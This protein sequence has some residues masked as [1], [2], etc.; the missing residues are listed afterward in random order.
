MGGLRRISILYNG[1]SVS[2]L[3]T[4][5]YANLELLL[6]FP[7]VITMYPLHIFPHSFSIL[8]IYSRVTFF[9]MGVIHPSWMLYFLRVM[10]SILRM[11]GAVEFTTRDRRENENS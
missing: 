10:L 11:L 5:K 9:K 4:P 7:S 8:K 2:P 6:L 1:V 3:K